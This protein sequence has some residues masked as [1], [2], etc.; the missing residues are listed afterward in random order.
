MKVHLVIKHSTH[1]EN[2]RNAK[3]QIVYT[4]KLVNSMDNARVFLEETQ[5]KIGSLCD[6]SYTGEVLM[7]WYDSTDGNSYIIS[8]PKGGD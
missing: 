2:G 1:D 4:E 8:E 7:A 6:E 3:G 5:E